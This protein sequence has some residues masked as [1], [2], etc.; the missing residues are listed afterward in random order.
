VR[1]W[2]AEHKKIK[3]VLKAIAL[4]KMEPPVLI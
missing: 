3:R 2:N 4:T 1:A